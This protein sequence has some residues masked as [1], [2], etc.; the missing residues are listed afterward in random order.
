MNLCSDWS[1]FIA[2]LPNLEAIY[3]T[4]EQRMFIQRQGENPRED[5]VSIDAS[6]MALVAM[7]SSAAALE[8]CVFWC[9]VGR[10]QVHC[11]VKNNQF[12]PFFFMKI[13]A[14]KFSGG[15]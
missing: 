8:Y 6:H 4:Q 1:D 2:C 5:E 10:I 15:E 3:A 7:A 9:K 14:H 11:Q 12:K 13:S